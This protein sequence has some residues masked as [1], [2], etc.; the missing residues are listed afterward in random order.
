[1]CGL[2]KKERNVTIYITTIQ[3]IA[4]VVLLT[5]TEAIV[6]ILNHGENESIGK[7]M[8]VRRTTS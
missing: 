1:M 7:T 3:M 5:M 2:V 8:K 6:H 4:I